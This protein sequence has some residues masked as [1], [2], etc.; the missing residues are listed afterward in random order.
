[1]A[2]Y[3]IA[4]MS[5][6]DVA[7]YG[8]YGA[9]VP[10]TIVQYGG[11]ILVAND[12]DVKEG[13]PPYPRTVMGEFPDMESAKKWYESPEYQALIPLRQAATD[14]VLFMVEGLTMPSEPHKSEG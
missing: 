1:M 2:A 10:A 6:H 3:V 8:E 5:V 7:K 4:Q 13:S 14:G 11:K 12:I 9:G